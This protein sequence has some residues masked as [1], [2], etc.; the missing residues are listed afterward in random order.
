MAEEEG[1]EKKHEPGGRSLTEALNQGNVAMSPDLSAAAALLVGA[2][3]MIYGGQYMA[4]PV[5]GLSRFLWEGAAKPLNLSEAVTL[6]NT[7][8]GVALYVSLIPLVAIAVVGSAVIL[9][10]TRGNVAWGTLEWKLDSL[11]PISGF[12]NTFLSWTPIV[13]LVKGVLKITFLTFIV[14]RVVIAKVSELPVLAS[15]PPHQFGRT[16]TELGWDLIRQAVPAMLLI[17]AADYGVAW[18]RRREGLMRTDQEVKDENKQMEGSPIVRQKQ[19]QRMMEMAQ[20][21]QL[22]K[23][24]TADVLVTNP[25]HFAVALRYRRDRDEAPVILSKGTDRLA[26]RM[27]IEADRLGIPRMED[28][29]LARALYAKGRVGRAIPYDLYGPVAKL[30]AVVYRRRRKLVR[31]S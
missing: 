21:N 20:G 2:V 29:P 11:N 15:V 4:E 28:R 26:L 9:A 7:T 1:Q 19:R 8:F 25:T 12:R 5:L 6:V 14:G 24:R 18:W 10:Q 30:L 31:G 16:L 22:I 13:E 3:V 23:M 17:G 27:R